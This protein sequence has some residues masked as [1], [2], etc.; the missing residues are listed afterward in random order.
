MYY[1]I[2]QSPIGAITVATDGAYLT[3]LHIEGDRYFTAVPD[4][5]QRD[6]SQPILQTAQA[7]LAGYF[8]GTQ[9]TFDVPLLL[10]GTAFQKAVWQALRSIP[11]GRTVTYGALAR[12]IGKPAAARAVGTAVGRNPI[13]II[14]PCHRVLASDGTIGGYVAGIERKQYL[15]DNEA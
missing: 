2:L 9:K 4:S 10:R 7:Q 6:P 3:E 11:P 1:D 8:A 13:C 12:D 14:I 5:W 15:L